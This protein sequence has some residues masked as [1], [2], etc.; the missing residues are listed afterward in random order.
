MIP[1][2]VFDF[3]TLGAFALAAI[4]IAVVYLI[5]RDIRLIMQMIN[6]LREEFM[7]LQLS[8]KPGEDDEEDEDGEDVDES[9][10]SGQYVD[11]DEE[12]DDVDEAQGEATQ[13]SAPPVEEATESRS[14]PGK[15]LL[16]EAGM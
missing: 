5:Y 12:E 8:F 10:V 15:C 16:S 9:L 13:N 7:L 14:H 3:Q 11:D 6:D 1:C 2:V 4:L